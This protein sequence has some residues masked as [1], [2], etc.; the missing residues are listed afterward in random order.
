MTGGDKAWTFASWLVGFSVF[1]IVAGL[2]QWG[3]V[4]LYEAWWNSTDAAGQPIPSGTIKFIEWIVGGGVGL[5]A[6]KLAGD[7]V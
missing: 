7:S 3:A 6:G 4:A 5:I 1:V 2:V